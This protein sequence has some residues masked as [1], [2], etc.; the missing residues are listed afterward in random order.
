M[1]VYKFGGASVRNGEN[2]RQL[3]KIV[4]SAP[5]PLVVVVSAMGKTTNALERIVDAYFFHN[6]DWQEE[7]RKLWDY[8]FSVA[9]DLF[10]EGKEVFGQLES[11]FSRLED[12]L[13]AQPS[14]NYDYD[15]D[16]IVH[17]GELLSTTII[18]H[19]LN[20]IGIKNTWIDARSVIK[21]D[22][23]F[24]QA[25]IDWG[26]TGELIK[27]KID[28]RDTGLY[29]TQG[30]IASDHNGQPV[31]LG[32]EGSDFSAAIFAWALGASRLTV[33]KD[34]DG[35]YSA[36]PKYYPEARRFD[37]LSYRETTELAY[38]GAKVI[39]PKTLKPL[40]DKSIPLHV[41]SFLS[42]DRGG[43]VITDFDQDLE[44]RI[45]VVI[46]KEEQTL[47]SVSHSDGSFITEPDMELIFSMINRHKI[48]NN[49]MQRS[50][51][52]LSFCVDYHR[53]H[54]P[55]LIEDLKRYF[56]VKYNTD[57]RLIT[58]RHYDGETIKKMTAGK[59]I[60]LH[61]QS[62]TNAYFVVR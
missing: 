45:P 37:R 42:P 7:F 28:F 29:I 44:P 58:I 6:R 21:T 43:T 57:L 56:R 54:L 51:L 5:R 25:D 53:V 49:V 34:V 38:Y 8:H 3:A 12:I 41:R 13:S 40:K 27:Q 50:A 48:N 62:R 4:S 35:I 26:A 22:S 24:R 14:M 18:S 52:S 61:Q 20:D 2:I 47:V 15:Y 9:R 60:L 59:E 33:W 11:L 46:I 30:F 31:T 10:D 36:D 19:Y 39:H 55:S 17:F 32:R 23:N 1:E 16:R